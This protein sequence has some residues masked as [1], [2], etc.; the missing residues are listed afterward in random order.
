MPQNLG[1]YG[2][3]THP[4]LPSNRW[5]KINPSTATASSAS[6]SAGGTRAVLFAPNRDCTL[7]GLAL[8]IVTG[9]AGGVLR[10]GLYN[11]SATGHRAGALIAE[12]GTSAAA[13]SATMS[14]LTGLS[15]PLE[16]Q[17]RYWIAVAL[18]VASLGYRTIG[19]GAP[20]AGAATATDNQNALSGSAATG[21]L[22][23]SF[24][25]TST[26]STCPNIYIRVT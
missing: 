4:V 26:S 22:N 11:D 24:N 12:L 1:S 8:Y 3:V 10:W 5:M 18:Q 19:G 16:G 13:T 15:Q 25:T 21:A 17:R 9:G 7:E 23:A 2:W 14:T 6:T 20:H